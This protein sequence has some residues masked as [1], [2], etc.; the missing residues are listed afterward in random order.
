[1]TRRWHNVLWVMMAFGG[2]IFAACDGGLVHRVFS[3]PDMAPIRFD[4]GQR[5]DVGV[6]L[7]SGPPHDLPTAFHDTGPL[8]DLPTKHLDPCLTGKCG[9]GMLCV[10]NICHKACETLPTDHC[11]D[12]V[13]ACGAGEACVQASSFSEACFAADPVG[14]PCGQGQMC[15]AGTLCVNT[16]KYVRCLKLCKYGCA[17][18]QCGTTQEYKCS[19]CLL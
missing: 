9:N 17:S 10:A 14:S 2:L 4:S 12:K 3:H 13:P 18:G 15:A 16:G 19:I 8:A 1:M 5:L 6:R 7:D 11:N